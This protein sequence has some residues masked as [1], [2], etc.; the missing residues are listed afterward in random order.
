MSPSWDVICI[1][2]KA[3]LFGDGVGT[4][5]DVNWLDVFK[6]SQKQGITCI[7]FNGL[8]AFIPKELAQE[9]ADYNYKIVSKNVR[10]VY[11]QKK[12]CERLENI[13]LCILKG[14]AA[15]VYYPQPLLRAM[16]D[17]DFIVP[18]EYFGQVK[19]LLIQSDY[20]L[21]KEK[22]N[23]TRHISFTKNQILFEMHHRFGHDEMN[24][25]YYIER[26][27]ER[28]ELCSITNTSFP[29][30][31]KLENGLVLLAHLRQHLFSGIGMRQVID[32][33]MY[34]DRELSDE[35]WDEVFKKEASSLGMEKLAVTTTRLCQMYFGLKSDINWCSDADEKLCD[36][37]LESIIQSGNFGHNNGEG[38]QIEKTI[39]NFKRK[40]VFKYL[41][42]AGE[43]NWKLYKRCHW[44]RPFASIYQIIRFVSQGI[45]TGRSSGEI[46]TDISRSKK[47]MELLDDLGLYV[48]E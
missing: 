7:I 47:R 19:N 2:L 15:A 35:Y 26:C 17:I 31:P 46:A 18:A 40:G 28:R 13:P 29:M 44:L 5:P 24:I 45:K 42:T 43:H 21:N 1:G 33:M 48:I 39:V 11:E 27:Y 30:L 10:L 12:L 22:E 14:T 23:D 36:R 32:W 25:D 9:W 41:Q 4:L 8:K 37:L 3:S 6:E 20:T 34:V 38:K 16:G